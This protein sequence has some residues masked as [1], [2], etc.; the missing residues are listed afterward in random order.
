M[1]KFLVLARKEVV[2]AFRDVSGL[3]LM[4][5]TPFMLTLAV[6]AAL[7]SESD[8]GVQSLPVLVHNADA[9]ALGEDLVAALQSAA[10]DGYLSPSV[11]T[12]AATARALVDA[13]AAVALVEVPPDLTA[14][15]T[16]G[17]TITD[18]VVIELY[19]SPTQPI[20]ASIVKSVVSQYV[21]QL[22][23]TLGGARQLLIWLS[24]QS[25]LDPGQAM[26]AETAMV[27][28]LGRR[29][30]PEG[31]SLDLQTTTGQ[32][33]NWLN[34]FAPSLAML[35]LMFVA[36]GGGRTIIAE[37]QEGTLPRLLVSPTP[38]P[39]ILLGKMTGAMVTGILQ[40]FILWGA[41]SLVGARWGDP[42]P[43]TLSILVLVFCTSGLGALI[44][45]VVR[46]TVQANMMGAL[47]ALVAAALSGNFSP[48]T[49]LPAWSQW[50][51][52]STPNGWGLELFTRMQA[53]AG[54]SELWPW[55]GGVL[56]LSCL[57]YSLALWLLQ[58]RFK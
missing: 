3:L 13:D 1:H 57:Y 53:G 45:A 20:G 40:V 35:F 16:A 42:L 21:A 4:L 50:M 58:R 36:T 41:T 19:T 52:L 31:F 47:V 24:A 43:V 12:D 46:T 33:F 49:N 23:L 51:S 30:E 17:E 25:T 22:N 34:Y 6:A 9:G 27:A 2:L 32:A 54:L 44:A 15:L 29:S 56:L 38:Q 14:R 37:M 26:A 10:T 7:G 5:V 28:E 8:A 18:P 39:V 11:V 48:R 55:L